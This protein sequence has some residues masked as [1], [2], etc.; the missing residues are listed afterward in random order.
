MSKGI[1]KNRKLRIL[2]RIVLVIIVLLVS[3]LWL[4]WSSKR[5]AKVM[6][7]DYC[8]DTNGRYYVSPNINCWN[9]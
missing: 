3:I 8:W 5:D 4:N 2:K 1:E 6:K 7:I 9:Q